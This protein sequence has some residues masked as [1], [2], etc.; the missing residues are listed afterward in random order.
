MAEEDKKAEKKEDKEEDKEDK[1]DKAKKA[2][3]EKKDKRDVVVHPIVLLSVVDHYNRVA[4]GTTKRVVGTLLG[5]V[6]DYKRHITNCFAVPFEEDPRD[7][8]VWFL[9]HN[10]HENMYAMFKKVNAKEQVIGWY[11]TGPKIKPSDLSIHE[12]Y[13]RYCPE[14]VLV[15]MDVQ[16][17]D[18]ELPMEAYYSVQEETS[19]QVFKRT[20]FHVQSTV[21][22]FEA[23]EVGVEHLLR[24]IKNASASTLAVRVGDKINAMKGL[25]MRLREI[26]SYL[27]LVVEGK[28]PMNQEI[29]YQLQEIF[30]LMPDQD[31]E[32][33]VRSFAMET[34]D[35]MLAL[36]LGSMLRSTVALHNLINNKV[37]NKK[38]KDGKG[39]EK[40]SKKDD[41]GKEKKE[42]EKGEDEKETSK[43]KKEEK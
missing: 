31:K 28:L 35:M 27:S 4:K 33:L 16:P 6:N 18:S 25:A 32:E 7:P 2:S 38:L 1:E 41:E 24:D 9:D 42:G 11:S 17:K 37:R 30:N 15:V 19:D 36:Y 26:S 14:P 13:R 43:E 12:L 8:Q 22:A 10:F 34:N 23:E 21:G 39:D 3:A 20:F 29:I 5:E 40:K